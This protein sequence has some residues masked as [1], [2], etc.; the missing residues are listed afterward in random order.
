MVQLTIISILLSGSL[1]KEYLRDIFPLR[2]HFYNL[3][4]KNLQKYSIFLFCKNKEIVKIPES[5]VGNLVPDHTKKIGK[6]VTRCLEIFILTKRELCDPTHLVNHNR[7]SIIYA[8]YIICPYICPYKYICHIR[9]TL[10]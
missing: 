5:R 6:R 8:I 1:G 10:F 4:D 3:I 9:R 2:N 7:E